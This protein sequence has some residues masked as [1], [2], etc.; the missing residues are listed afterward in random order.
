MSTLGTW[1]VGI[2][3]G[4]LSSWDDKEVWVCQTKKR[5]YCSIKEGLKM[6]AFIHLKRTYLIMFIFRCLLAFWVSR[7]VHV[8]VHDFPF[9]FRKLYF[10]LILFPFFPLYFQYNRLLEDVQPEPVWGPQL[11]EGARG[12]RPEDHHRPYLQRLR[13][14]LWVWRLHQAVPALEH[15]RPELELPGG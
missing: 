3:M 1:R 9:T 12:I 10:F 5:F 2:I 4:C 14:Q 15:H 8:C 13:L 11:P 6:I 7:T